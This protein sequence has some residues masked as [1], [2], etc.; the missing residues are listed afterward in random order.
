MLEVTLSPNAGFCFGV[1]RAVEEAVKAKDNCNSKIYTLGPLIHNEDA[2]NNLISKGIFPIEF[3]D[4]DNLHSGDI[5]I[6]RSHGVTPEIINKLHE[7]KLTVV[8]ATCPYVTNIQKKVQK[9]YNLGY[10]IIIVGDENHPEVIGINGWCNNSAFISK[11]G[12]NLLNPPRKVC[13]LSQTTEKQANWERVMNKISAYSKEIV[14]FNTICSATEIRQR[15]AAE[16]AQQV[17]LMVVIGG[18]HSS[19]TTKLY[20]I[21][22]R[23]CDN[24]IHA[25]SAKDIP[26]SIL[27][28]I[29]KIGI[30]AGASTP[31]WIIKE[32]IQKM[33]ETNN[34]EINELQEYMDAHTISIK[35]GEIIE[36]KIISLNEKTAFVNIGYKAD[37]IL[38][39]EEVSMDENVKLTD[40]LKVGDVV[41]VKIISRRNDDGYV[42]LSRIEM[43]REKYY[44]NLKEAFENGENVNVLVKESVKG[45]LVCSYNGVRVF[46]PASHVELQHVENLTSYIGKTFEVK[47]IE[48]SEKGR[49]TK[50]IASRRLLLKEAQKKRE[51]EAWG[52]IET[53]D[54]ISAEV[55]RLTDFGAFLDV[56]G[57]DGLLHVSE[58]S[59]NRINNPKDILK[60]GDNV[61]VK[62]IDMDKEAK[63]LSLSI[64]ALSENPWNNVEE[65]YPVDNIVLGKV[66][67]FAAFGAFVELEPGIDGLVHISQIAH[68]HIEKPQD[69]L[70]IGE[71]IKAKILDVN[72]DKKKISLS[73]K[74]VNQA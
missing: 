11:D 48:F 12:N 59:W 72:K 61:D 21:C 7:M 4:I 65:K 20:E 5:I 69:A 49:S 9:Y 8:D 47:I 43:E 31:D 58:M 18:K 26:F 73:I 24:T 62:I 32:A 3:K 53:G 42:V 45:G 25:E 41:A 38:P 16:I 74:E 64:K 39:K 52:T 60:V 44:S 70:Q 54:V 29:N 56:K 67:R 63:K 71:Q 13:V 68:K 28:N 51:D 15:E 6:I 55:K 33:M 46:L 1:K 30:T 14:A 35:V 37:G 57:V 27:N 10:H 17:E 22:K 40:I 2:V 50:I 66:V 23:Y 34:T 19:N 36:G